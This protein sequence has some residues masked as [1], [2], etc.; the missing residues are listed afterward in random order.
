MSLIAEMTWVEFEKHAQT[1]DIV[2]C[3]LGAVEVYGPHL[4][5]GT[6]GLVATALAVRVAEQ[7]PA[8]VAPLLPVGYSLS[9]QEFPGTL[10]VSPEAFKAYLQGIC[11][12]FIQWGCRRF[13]FLNG[14]LG[15]VAP[16]AQL[17]EELRRSHGA[18]CAQIDIWRFIQPLTRD[19]MESTE[20]PFGH[21][22]EAGTS[23]VLYL[24]EDKVDKAA[25]TRTLP[26]A[27]AFPE[28]LKTGSYR[29]KSPTG[30]VGD[31]SKGSAE[32]GKQIIERA[33]E[34]IVAF[35]RSKEFA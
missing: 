1:T 32:K 29:A 18:I 10:N 24:A 16:V 31:A 25:A 15:N 8:F 5:M 13:L 30:I 17:S 7:V 3:P 11:E 26:P 20:F 33:V 34:R 35:I 28:I 21:A 27:D 4:P 12:S 2:L 19:L 6:D 14:H 9:L 23:V 22:S